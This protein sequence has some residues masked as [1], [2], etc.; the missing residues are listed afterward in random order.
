MN[1]H[2]GHGLQ[3]EAAV[4]NQ[5][6]LILN[7]IEIIFRHEIG[8]LSFVYGLASTWMRKLQAVG[9][10]IPFICFSYYILL[11]Y[12]LLPDNGQNVTTYLGFNY[13]PR[14][15]LIRILQ[16]WPSF[17]AFNVMLWELVPC[18]SRH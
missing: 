1:G 17:Y 5:H 3:N 18:R 13:S 2:F 10:V 8:V 15:C 6:Y 4:I 16:C 14:E 7:R 12:I 11:L 9:M